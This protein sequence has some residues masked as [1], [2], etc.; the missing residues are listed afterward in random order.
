MRLTC[1]KAYDIRGKV[2]EEL[3]ESLAYEIGVAFASFVKPKKVC[4]GYDVRPSSKALSEKLIQGIVDAGVDV[5]D[6]GLCGSEEVYF[7]TFNENL[8]GGVMITASHNPSN[9]NGFK[10]VRE[11]GIPI[12]IETGLKEIHQLVEADHSKTLSKSHI[13]KVS[14]EQDKSKYIDFLLGLFDKSILKP[15]K[16]VVNPGNGCAGPVLRLLEKS[17]PF[18]FIFVNETPDGTFPNGVPNPMLVENRNATSKAVIDNHADLGL[19]W[20]GDFDRCFFFDKKGN[21][22][23]GAYIVGVLAKSILM[24][25]PKQKIVHDTRVWWSIVEAIEES[26]GQPIP[27]VSGHAFIKARMRKEDAVYGG[28]ISAHHYFKNFS[29]C[30][31]GMLA[32]IYIIQLLCKE[33]ADLSVFVEHMEK[34]Y[35][36]SG[37]INITIDGEPDNKVEAVINKYKN[38][39]EGGHVDNLDGWSFI[40]SKENVRVNIRKSNT[41]PLLRVNLEGRNTTKEHV[42]KVLNDIL[43]ILKS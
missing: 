35:P 7:K 20:D 4:V 6:I 37:E 12:G 10:F 13:G 1:V 38:E 22:I 33:G 15:L 16:V 25:N 19:A 32:W 27:S 31:S 34:K 41:E 21:F 8:D 18:K 39:I 36:I 40:L 3:N 28:E 17:L 30:D 14:I 24:T 23:E 11:K 26:N 2:P 43:A 5:V 9:Y 29:Y 42:D